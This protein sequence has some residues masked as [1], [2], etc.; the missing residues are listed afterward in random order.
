MKNFLQKIFGNFW[1][2]IFCLILAGALWLY[3]GVGQ[4]KSSTFPG[5]VPLQLRNVP[6]GLV[7]VTDVDKVKVDV[8]T[9]NDVFNSLNA[10]SF[11]A[12][13]DLTG[14]SVGT[15][16]VKVTIVT[17]VANVQIVETNPSTV[18]I[19]LEP[20]VEKEVQISCLFD[21]QAGTGMAPGQC[22]FEPSTV[23]ISGAR[24]VVNS[25]TET[26]AK[27]HLQN[28]TADFKKSVSLVS[29][30]ARGNE[31]KNLTFSP[32]EVMV[33]VPIV[34]ASNIKTVGIKVNTSGI[35]A[36]GYWVS[37]IES[38]PSTITINAADNIISSISYIETEP[39]DVNN[40][41]KNKTVEVSLKP[42]SGVSILDKI[43][44]VKVTLTISKN[45]STR[46]V[47]AGFKWLNLADNLKVTS[48]D[49]SSVK[50]VAAGSQ[51]QLNNLNSG[52]IL[53]Q[54][55]LT[56]FDAP[57]TYSVDISRANISGPTGVS[58]SSIVPSA[59]NIRLDT[60]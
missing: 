37:K 50:I 21:G 16:D 38:S 3:V 26:T 9:Q 45:Q 46:E 20:K 28:E 23:K 30:D 8:V 42:S 41:S 27:I 19:R 39:I 6:Q 31:I 60:K 4:T 18:T 44:K 34:K 35:P 48:A 32:A 29:I 10:D 2:K 11:S 54:V 22:G 58:V 47:N 49:P 51:D 14:L 53:V 25:I 55:D 1:A 57:G 43:D 13:L 17:A 36:D 33:T 12:Y 24:S 5:G 52:D 40:I 7:P 59:I 56:G 15:Y